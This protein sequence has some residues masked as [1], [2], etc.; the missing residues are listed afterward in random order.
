M[1]DPRAV[2]GLQSRRP[3]YRAAHREFKNEEGLTGG[4]LFVLYDY[5]TLNFGVVCVY[6]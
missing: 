6:T 4:G 3:W 1:P 2:I 5:E